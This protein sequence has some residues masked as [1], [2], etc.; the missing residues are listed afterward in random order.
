MGAGRVRGCPPTLDRLI[1][2]FCADYERRKEAIAEGSV[3]MR[4]E[5]EYKYLNH[6]IFEGAAE[7]V[8]ARYA[9]LYINEI[10]KGVGYANSAHPA[11]CESSY[12]TEKQQVKLGIA[13]KLHLL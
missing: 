12:K 9:E 8:G 7:A 1:V 11:S 4:I 5:M 3:P 13:G 2:A 6:R 10:G